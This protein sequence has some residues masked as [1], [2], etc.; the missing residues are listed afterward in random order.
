MCQN[1]YGKSLVALSGFIRSETMLAYR[2]LWRVALPIVY[3]RY[4][5]R[6]TC[7]LSDGDDA[8]YSNIDRAIAAGTCGIVGVTQRRRCIFH[9]VCQGFSKTYAKYSYEDNGTGMWVKK[10]VLHACYSAES[11]DQFHQLWAALVSWVD[12]RRASGFIRAHQ[13]AALHTF[14]DS[15]HH[16]RSTVSKAF[17]PTRSYGTMTTSRCEG[18]NLALKSTGL[19]SNRADLA[20]VADVERKRQQ[21]K[22]AASALREIR[23][24]HEVPLVAVPLLLADPLHPLAAIT[25]KAVALMETQI[26]K[27]KA[28]IS[29]GVTFSSDILAYIVPRL[30]PEADSVRVSNNSHSK[31]YTNATDI[32]ATGSLV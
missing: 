23:R 4:L 31:Q 16:D 6:T 12:Q 14:L 26:A 27:A 11:I 3:G 29:I 17:T 28:K 32:D 19:V 21:L 2:F 22:D 1:G 18:E 25:P 15:V 9:L 30:P 24:R 8:I 10:W 13:H 5:A 20:F 7:V